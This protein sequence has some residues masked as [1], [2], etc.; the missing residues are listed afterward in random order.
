MKKI[1]F[2]LALFITTLSFGQG[3]E[4]FT[5]SNATASYTSN[6]FTG[7]NGV[8]WTYVASRDENGDV[9]AS[10]ISGKAIMLRRV[11]DLS[12]VTSSSVAGGIGDF[13]VKLYKGFTGAGDRQVELFVNGVSRGTS[14]VF[15]NYLENVFT[16]TGINQPGNI[17]IELRNTTS[18]QII[19]DDISWT[20][21]SGAT[22]P[23]LL[24]TS[25]ANATVYNPLTTSVDI[26]LSVLNFN[27]A[28]GTGDGHIHYVINSLPLVMKYDTDPIALTGLTPGAYSVYV[29]LVD[30]SHTPIVPAVNATVTFDIATLNVVANLGELRSDVITNGVGKYYEISGNPIIT[31][32]RSTRNQKYIQDTSAGILIDDNTAVISTP[33]AEGDA[34]SGLKG[35]TSLFNGLLQILPLEDATIASSGNIVTPEVVTIADITGNLEAYESELVRINGVTFAD[36]NGANTF[37]SN[38]NY[39]IADANTIAFRTMFSEAD[40]VTNTDLIPN[41]ATDIVVLVAKFNTTPQVV[42]RSL[43]ELTLSTNSFDAIDGLSMYP[44]PVSGNIL[45]FSSA[46]NAE[47]NVQIFDILGKQILTSKVT[48]NALNVS[49]LNSGIYIVKITE[50]GKTATRKLVVK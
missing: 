4:T 16:V 26:D 15:D 29:E 36:G 18:R 48:N 13:S 47:M 43:A 49:K 2:L 22:T 3:L 44:N 6:S 34:I 20:G 25:P 10:G 40:Y 38:T 31:Y 19:V 23:A 9:N 14:A 11:S 37:A 41:G 7:D 1:Y 17:I 45:N 12:S 8:T 33:M 32:A 21:Y 46:L 42:A 39:N 30:N 24:I 35:Q 5:N 27:V 50:E 28:N